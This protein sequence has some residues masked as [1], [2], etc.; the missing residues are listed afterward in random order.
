MQTLATY[1]SHGHTL[2]FAEQGCECERPIGKRLL[3]GPGEAAEN[4]VGGD[5]G[6]QVAAEHP[7][8]LA[9]VNDPGDEPGRLRK[10]SGNLRREFF[11]IFEQNTL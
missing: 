1:A 3:G 10:D 5:D 6:V 8:S 4:H 9:V 11:V 7:A 2:G